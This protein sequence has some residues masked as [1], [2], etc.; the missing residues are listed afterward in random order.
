M[1]NKIT[2]LESYKDFPKKKEIKSSVYN[3]T[4][5]L[6]N[7]KIFQKTLTG[8]QVEEFRIFKYKAKPQNRVLSYMLKKKINYS[9]LHTDGYT[10]RFVW[11]PPDYLNDW[12]FILL[13]THKRRNFKIQSDEPTMCE[14]IKEHGMDNFVESKTRLKPITQ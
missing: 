2:T 9:N 13:R 3:K 1:K 6:I 11:M 8:N 4:I 10:A 5:K 14:H 12:N 7:K